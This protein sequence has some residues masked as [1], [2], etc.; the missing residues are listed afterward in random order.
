MDRKSP[1]TNI[2]LQKAD[3]VASVV[4]DEYQRIAILSPSIDQPVI[5]SGTGAVL[6]DI[7]DDVSTTQELIE[8]V[9]EIYSA[10][11]SEVRTDVDRFVESLIDQR[12][13][14]AGT[15]PRRQQEA[16]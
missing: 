2:F 16:R 5:L 15:V 4:S 11:P 14:V 7:L 9:A 13:L 1:P 8:R 10:D 3:G 12:L 6:W